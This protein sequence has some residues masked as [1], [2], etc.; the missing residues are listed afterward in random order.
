MNSE[1]QALVE[2]PI[3]MVIFLSLVGGVSRNVAGRQGR[4]TWLGAVSPDL[5]ALGCLHSLRAVHHHAAVFDGGVA[6][7]GC[8]V[9]VP[10]RDGG[11]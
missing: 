1:Q 11:C 6:L 8:S 2:M 9:R 7:V 3:W 5:A 4:C 10:D